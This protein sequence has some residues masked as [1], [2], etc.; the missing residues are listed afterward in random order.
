MFVSWVDVLPPWDALDE[1]G[2]EVPFEDTVGLGTLIFFDI[3]T[4]TL[5]LLDFLCRR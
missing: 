3:A 4:D 1:D 5:A 2:N